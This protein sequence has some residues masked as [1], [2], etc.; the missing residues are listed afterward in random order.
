MEKL[1][2]NKGQSGNSVK[3]ADKNM[4][5]NTSDKNLGILG[6]NLATKY[7]LKNGYK[8]LERNY[9]FKIKNGPKLGEIDIIAE[10]NGKIFFFEVKTKSKKSK[11]KP[12]E[13]VNLRKIKKIE[14]IAQIWLDSNK[15]Y[16]SQQWEVGIIAININFE[17]KI[18]K[19]TCFKNV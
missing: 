4:T 9:F 5:N 7:L 1:G 11:I 2:K 17:N 13:R 19:I 10:N 15:R 18:A 12:E 8:I 16:F 6:E 3:T 14:Q